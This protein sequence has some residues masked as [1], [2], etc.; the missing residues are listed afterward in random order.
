MT[1]IG[2]YERALALLDALCLPLGVEPGADMFGPEGLLAKA[3]ALKAR[4]AVAVAASPLEGQLDALRERVGALA[5]KLAGH[6]LR[7]DALEARGV[8][9][10]PP[11]DP[12]V[13]VPR[14]GSDW[15]VE[16]FLRAEPGPGKPFAERLR[17]G[18]RGVA[19]AVAIEAGNAVRQRLGSREI[20]AELAG[21]NLLAI[22][23]RIDDL[24]SD[25]AR[26]VPTKPE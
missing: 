7:L 6:E 14:Q 8:A 18:C 2:E 5:Q 3:T 10:A 13:S 19:R 12:F 17:A 22:A 1:T 16:A 25:L 23:G 11:A 20:G 4:V 26:L 21:G 24:L 9:P 15:I